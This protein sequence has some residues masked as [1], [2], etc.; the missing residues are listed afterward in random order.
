MSFKP[1]PPDGKVQDLRNSKPKTEEDIA[2][3]KQAKNDKIRR[4]LRLFALVLAGY[5]FASAGYSWYQENQSE[6]Q[7]ITAVN[8]LNPLRDPV[9]FRSTFNQLINERDTSL[10]TA[11]AN[12]TPEGF[13][14]VLS[15]AV[16]IK[17]VARANSKELANVQIQTRYPD[18]FPP[19]SINA[20]QTFVLACERLANPQA[21]QEQ[22]D[23]IL[24]SLG[25]IPRVDANENDKLFPNTSVTSP[26]YRY[27]TTFTSGPIDELTLVA[28][29]LAHEQAQAA[30]T[31]STDAQANDANQASQ[32]T[33]DNG[34]ANAESMDA[35]APATIDNGSDVP[36]MDN[37]SD[38]PMMDADPSMELEQP[39]A[40]YPESDVPSL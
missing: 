10:P 26:A 4:N 6:S 2:Q 34:A 1:I 22:A 20:F 11:N 27:E 9:A 38:V 19:E 30:P 32:A 15:T 8:E 12:D 29:P 14:A 24:D 7:A 23:G 21:T 36:V 13:I 37:N 39:S 3:E 40:A 31:A 28:I 33:Q 18:A 35:N 5:Y 16:E 25:I 17:G